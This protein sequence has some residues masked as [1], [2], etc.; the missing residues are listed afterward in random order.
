MRYHSV[1]YDFTRKISGQMDTVKINEFKKDE[2]IFLHPGKW[3]EKSIPIPSRKFP[4]HLQVS[5]NIKTYLIAA[6]I[7]VTFTACSQVKLPLPELNEPSATIEYPP[8][9]TPD[10]PTVEGP[11]ATPTTSPTPTLSATPKSTRTPRPTSTL[12]ATIPPIIRVGPDN[13][14]DYV[15]P[16]TGFPAT[17]PLLLERRP[18]AV[19]IPNYPHNVYPQSGLTSADHIFEYHLEQGL[20]RFI[21]I[22]Y[23]QDATRVGPVR[24]GRI[25]DAYI[26][27]MYNAV[28]VFNYA[29]RE[30]GNDSL[31][32]YGYLE[33][34]LNED[35]FV[36]DPGPCE[37]YMCRDKTINSYNN[38]FANTYGITELINQR[39]QENG[40]Q[41]L[42]TN[43]FNSLGGRGSHQVAQ[44][45]VNYSYANYAYWLYD[46]F[47]QRYLR[48]QGNV[49]LVG[50]TEPSYILLTDANNDQP[51]MAD[52]VI[53][54]Y[55]PHEFIYKSGMSEVFDIKLEGRGDAY[56][57]RNG[58]VFE[59]VWERKE[60]NKPLSILLP[61]GSP[62][63]LKPG[64]T[65]FQVLHTASELEK[66]DPIWI[67]NFNRP[68]D[69]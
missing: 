48:Y 51:V 38:L 69:E 50:D 3:L 40:R 55:V 52:N 42:A 4:V 60:V 17:N 20:T 61:N 64:I 14:P 16:L 32:V 34:N 62:F 22:F 58:S 13:F 18:I 9:S 54:L 67:F 59:A 25:F 21:A 24:S 49:D 43:F 68:E 46:K 56:V 5:M 53:I 47:S 26:V 8:T 57:F 45:Q 33:E 65:F 11:L 63:P 39:G 29:Y 28:F 6:I 2:R 37:P 35:L 1:L 41:D 19:K 36:V 31:D 12:T 10:Q 27:Q 7:V 30:E 66:E 15:N 44:I 23:G